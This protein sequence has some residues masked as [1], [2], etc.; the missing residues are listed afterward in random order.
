MAVIVSILVLTL[1]VYTQMTVSAELTENRNEQLRAAAEMTADNVEQWLAQKSGQARSLSKNPSIA[2]SDSTSQSVEIALQQENLSTSDSLLAIHYINPT[3]EKILQSTEKRFENASLKSRNLRWGT[4]SEGLGLKGIG[5]DNAGAMEVYTVDNESRIAFGRATQSFTRAVVMVYSLDARSEQF[6]NVIDNG[7]TEVVST[8]GRVMIPSN[9]STA[10]TKVDSEINATVLRRSDNISS[11]IINR[12][13]ELLAFA[14]VKGT[15][16]VALKHVPTANA[17]ALKRTV[18]QHLIV[19]LGTALLGLGVLAAFVGR[20]VMPKIEAISEGAGKIAS[21]N[22]DVEIDDEGR[23]DEVGQVRDAFR[24]TTNYLRTVAS[25]ADAL[26]RQDF[27][28]P[29]LE[30]DVPGE[31]GESLDTMRADLQESIE[32]IEAARERAQASRKEAEAMA[33]SLQRQ[34]NEFS[35]VMAETAEGDLTQRLDEDVDNDAM[36]EVAT[37][38]NEMLA[39]LQT[40]LEDVRAFAE[41]VDSSAEDVAASANEVQR[42]SEDVSESVQEIAGGAD[43]QD[44][45]VKNASEELTD[46]SAAIEEVA[47]SADEVAQKSQRAADL[48]ETGSEYG[49]DALAEMDAVESQAET[50]IEEV[51]RLESAMDEIGDIAG[52]IDEIADQTNMLALNASIEAARAGEAG[53]G[54]AVVAD[55][56]KQLAQET[57]DATGD[58]EARIAE[59]Q[60]TTEHVVEDMYDVGDSVTEGIDAVED[61]VSV[62]EDL[63]EQVEE[64]NVGIQSINDATDDQASSTE[65]VV[66]MMDEVGSISEQ[67]AREAESVSAAA[68]EQTASI[69]EVSEQIQSLSDRSGEL[70]DAVAQFQLDDIELHTGVDTANGQD[71]AADGGRQD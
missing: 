20:D 37:A 65:E 11:G 4:S 27:D 9:E 48:G 8:S 71:A 59:V 53:E 40:T 64:A 19:L 12:G 21:G 67:T 22:L 6:R 32:E 52:L 25:Q 44:E 46:L 10:L 49:A 61:A 47:S 68:E 2:D 17:Y 13:D 23:I 7:T 50:T 41:D 34:A 18:Q 15:D 63:V 38:A 43:R 60:D 57:S 45:T 56:I 16:W 26:A 54:F 70:R 14:A 62:L 66:A 58:I 39:Q 24:E 35:K 42:V 69:T 3:T 55:E 36:A 30:E 5:R 1:G 28:D 31:L 51:E 29:A 33:Q